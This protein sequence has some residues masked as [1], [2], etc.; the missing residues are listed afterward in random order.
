MI[1]KINEKMSEKI[2]ADMTIGEAIQNNPKVAEI[3][4]NEGIHCVGCGAAY[5][6][7]IEQG[8]QGHGKSKEE[9]YKI[10]EKINKGE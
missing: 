2:T 8:M 4:L 6:E 5:W 7:T 10:V 9:V 3:L 1:N